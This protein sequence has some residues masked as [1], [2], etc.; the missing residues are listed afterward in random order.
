MVSTP[1]FKKTSITS[2]MRS[3]VIVALISLSLAALVWEKPRNQF[4][5]MIR[6]ET[7]TPPIRVVGKVIASV[8]L[9]DALGALPS[10]I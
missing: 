3:G 8:R 7:D 4:V 1:S 5:P 9:P 6:R 10:V 2:A